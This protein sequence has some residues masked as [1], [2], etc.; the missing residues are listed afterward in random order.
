[1]V[2][3]GGVRDFCPWWTLGVSGDIPG[4]HS[5]W[6]GTSGII[7]VEAKAAASTTPSA[8]GSPT[9][10]GS[11]DLSNSSTTL[12]NPPLTAPGGDGLQRNEHREDQ[13]TVLLRPARVPLSQSSTGSKVRLHCSA[14]VS[15]LEW[16][17]LPTLTLHSPHALSHEAS[18]LRHTWSLRC[19]S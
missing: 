14:L 13:E 10:Q 12:R 3:H 7:W 19:A 5:L 2:I 9:T 1:M 11:P 18:I 17:P 15:I 8:L 16:D 6:G 4:C